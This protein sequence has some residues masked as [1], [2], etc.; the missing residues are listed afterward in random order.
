MIRIVTMKIVRIAIMAACFGFIVHY[1][2]AHKNELKL[3]LNIE[4]RQILLMCIVY[5]PI[6]LCV[7]LKN[8]IILYKFDLK[9]IPFGDWFKVEV[10]SRFLNLHVQQGSNL[11]RSVFLKKYYRFPYTHFI[12]MVSTVTWLEIIFLLSIAVGLVARVYPDSTV[13]G[14]PVVGF[15]VLVVLFVVGLPYGAKFVLARLH[16]ENKTVVWVG[17]KLSVVLEHI[18]E[19][20]RDRWFLFQQLGLS[21]IIF[22]LTV[23]IIDIAFS[24]V[25]IRPSLAE[26][27]IFTVYTQLNGLINIT[28]ANLGISELVY[29]L[30]SKQMGFALGHGIVAYGLIRIFVYL[31]TGLLVVVFAR[32]ISVKK[33]LKENT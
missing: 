29:G 31:F 28:P 25:A 8:F 22:S 3:F 2:W 6:L 23:V 12:G 17:Q 20:S 16:F 1:F 26:L 4:P 32:S 24:V 5:L 27:V 11:Y 19:C 30:I 33:I 14:I 15:G 13:F 21:L 10:I 9:N 18:S 7:A